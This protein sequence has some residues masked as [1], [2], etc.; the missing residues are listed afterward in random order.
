MLGRRECSGE[1]ERGGVGRG[2][3]R[4]DVAFSGVGGGLCCSCCSRT[5]SS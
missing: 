1:G 4:D 2:R 5:G 3:D